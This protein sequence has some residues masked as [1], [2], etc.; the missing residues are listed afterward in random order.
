MCKPSQPPFE[1]RR[2]QLAAENQGNIRSQKQVLPDCANLEHV[3]RVIDVPAIT[4]GKVVQ[5]Y[6][7][8]DIQEAVAVL[9]EP[10]GSLEPEKIETYRNLT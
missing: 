5:V 8:A 2:Q 10:M 7:N 9:S 6:M 1:S 3:L 4:G